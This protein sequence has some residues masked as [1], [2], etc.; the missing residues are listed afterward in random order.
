VCATTCADAMTLS[1]TFCDGAGTC[2][3]GTAPMTC[4]NSCDA[5]PPAVCK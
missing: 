4:T 3:P 5:G 1:Q 2:G